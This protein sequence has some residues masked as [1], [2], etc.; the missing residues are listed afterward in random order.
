MSVCVVSWLSVIDLWLVYEHTRLRPLSQL[1]FATGNRYEMGYFLLIRTNRLSVILLL[2][3]RE[4]PQPQR[5]CGCG[6]GEL[7]AAL[8]RQLHPGWLVPPCEKRYGACK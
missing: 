3:I 1:S 8:R 6:L 7:A 4:G 5:P 2:V